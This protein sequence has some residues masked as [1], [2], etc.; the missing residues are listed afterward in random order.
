MTVEWL[1]V[2]PVI[3]LLCLL[4]DQWPQITGRLFYNFDAI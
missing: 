1:G 3:Y 2:K 4:F